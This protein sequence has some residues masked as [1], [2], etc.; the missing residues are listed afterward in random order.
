MVNRK[1]QNIDENNVYKATKYY[2]T[3]FNAKHKLE[4]EQL[5][6]KYGLPPALYIRHVIINLLE[7]HLA[8]V[9]AE[10]PDDK[11]EEI[12]NK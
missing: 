4:L 11:E 10:L 2:A 12:Y 5:A 3:G 7:G 9:E 8:F 1:K 6:L